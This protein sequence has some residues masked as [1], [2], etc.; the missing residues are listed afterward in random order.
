MVLRACFQG[1]HFSSLV[2]RKSVLSCV[3]CGCSRTWRKW[4]LSFAF[5][6]LV[7]SVLTLLLFFPELLQF[8]CFWILRCRL[9]PSSFRFAANNKW[10]QRNG[11]RISFACDEYCL[12]SWLAKRLDFRISDFV[13]SYFWVFSL[14]RWF[15][16]S[17][18]SFPKLPL[19]FLRSE[20]R[21]RLLFLTYSLTNLS[22]LSLK[23]LLGED[24]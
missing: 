10:F 24:V 3:D 19:L 21:C 16:I 7:I 18:S 14:F 13:K 23:R 6:L 5:H 8:L 1:I 9:L 22:F 12:T 2:K 17:I 15:Q 11:F 4:L 20:G